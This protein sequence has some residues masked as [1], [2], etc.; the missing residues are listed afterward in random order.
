MNEIK[1]IALHNITLT[2]LKVIMDGDPKK[3]FPS[4]PIITFHT[5]IKK[6]YVEQGPR[7]EK[8]SVAIQ[9]LGTSYIIVGKGVTVNK[10]GVHYNL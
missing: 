5:C 1:V 8:C 7:V 9:F 10:P 2:Y 3:S 4:E 6:H